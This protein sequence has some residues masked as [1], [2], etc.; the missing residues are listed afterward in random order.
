MYKHTRLHSLVLSFSVCTIFIMGDYFEHPLQICDYA[1]KPVV[2]FHH[3]CRLNIPL[4]FYLCCRT[5]PMHGFCNTK[6]L[7]M[8]SV[9]TSTYLPGQEVLYAS[10]HLVENLYEV[11]FINS[12]KQLVGPSLTRYNLYVFFSDKFCSPSF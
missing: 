6:G 3:V 5:Q 12:I 8:L 10:N 11:H 9:I 4:I 2:T 7:Q 1:I